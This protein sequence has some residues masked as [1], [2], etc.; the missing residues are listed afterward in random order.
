VVLTCLALGTLNAQ[1][2]VTNPGFENGMDGW[3]AGVGQL[4]TTSVVPHT[5][6]TCGTA[7]NLNSYATVGGQSL[8]GKLPAGQTYTWSA[9]MRVASGSPAIHMLLSQT[10]AAGSRSIMAT[11][12]LSTAWSQYTTTFSLSVTGT[13][14][15]LNILF[16]NAATPGV[17]LYLDDVSVTNSSPPLIVTS[18]NQ[19]VRLSWPT[20]AANYT[21]L[22]TTN[23]AS[24]V[25]WVAVS[26]T[27]QSNATA[28]SLTLPVTNRSRFFRLQSP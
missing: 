24:P 16:L 22:G 14:T 9:W 1:N 6:T 26:G 13:L 15:A 3:L 8:L 10:D 17:T 5:G 11:K 18:T 4:T 7:N 27:I 20:T 23:L 28:F 25:Q 19:S 12:T 2:L 21:L